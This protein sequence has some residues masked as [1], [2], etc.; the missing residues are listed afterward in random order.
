MSEERE[1][2]GENGVPFIG[3]GVHC[4]SFSFLPSDERSQGG[5]G[6]TAAA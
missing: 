3:D 2:M 6:Q 5:D 1:R 4:A